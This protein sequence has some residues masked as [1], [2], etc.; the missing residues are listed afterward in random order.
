MCLPLSP[1]QAPNRN[2]VCHSPEP[3]ISIRGARFQMCVCCSVVSNP[4]Q[5]RGLQPARLL[6]TWI[7][8][9][10][11]LEWVAMSFCRFQ[12]APVN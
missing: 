12:R 1:W 3:Q 6:Y 5:P 10:R 4:L 8:Q 9:A 7:L 11:I 2:V